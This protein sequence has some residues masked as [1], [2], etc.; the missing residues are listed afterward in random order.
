[1]EKGDMN[2]KETHNDI[3]DVYDQI[4]LEPLEIVGSGN[5]KQGNNIKGFMRFNRMFDDCNIESNSI[6]AVP[7]N[8]VPLPHRTPSPTENNV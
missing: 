4:K 8:F 7:Y 2:C 5:G 1:M 3:R 6:G